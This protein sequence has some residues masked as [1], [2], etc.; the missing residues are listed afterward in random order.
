MARQLTTARSQASGIR[1]KTT[2]KDTI[3]QVL[4]RQDRPLEVAETLHGGAELLIHRGKIHTPRVIT[5]AD[6]NSA[7]GNRSDFVPEVSG[8]LGALL[9]GRHKHD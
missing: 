6:L 9:A 8:L 1:L 2:L 4:R 5:K 7:S 3:K